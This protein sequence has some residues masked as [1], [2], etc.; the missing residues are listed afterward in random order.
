MRF[1][2][3]E[4]RFG[5]LL[6]WLV[7]FG[8]LPISLVSCTGQVVIEAH[9]C[10]T[11]LAKPDPGAGVVFALRFLNGGAPPCLGYVTRNAWMVSW[12]MTGIYVASTS[13]FLIALLIEAA[14]SNRLLNFRR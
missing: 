3:G 13:A 5:G 11:M 10:Q 2:G 12:I 9:Y 14:R 8:L 1:S 7:W 4:K 6:F